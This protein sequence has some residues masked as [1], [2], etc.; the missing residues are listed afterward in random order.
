MSINNLI[1]NKINDLNQ[2]ENYVAIFGL[3]PSKGARS[4][5]LWNKVFSAEK[6]KIKMLP[7]DVSPER[8]DE[9]FFAYKSIRIV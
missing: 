4:P 2:T 3:S 7:L 6:K 8:L 9:L 5:T 1:E